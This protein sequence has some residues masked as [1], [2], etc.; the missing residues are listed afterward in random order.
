MNDQMSWIPSRDEIDRMPAI[1]LSIVDGAWALAVTPHN[2]VKV[3]I[4]LVVLT[5]AG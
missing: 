5:A 4:K 1:L 3:Q 2:A